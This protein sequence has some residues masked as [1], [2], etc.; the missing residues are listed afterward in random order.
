MF[1]KTQNLPSIGCQTL[2]CL[3]IALYILFEFRIPIFLIA[4]RQVRMK[5][6]AMP[7]ASVHKYRYLLA[8]KSDVYFLFTIMNSESCVFCEKMTKDLEHFKKG[9]DGR[10][11]WITENEF[12]FVILALHPKVTGHALIISKRH[13][14]DVTELN[15]Y[16]SQSLGSILVKTSKLLKQSLNAGKIYAMTM[17]EHWEPEE[18]NP[19]SKHGKKKPNTTE[20]FHLHL[21]PRYEEMR[22]KEIA[23]EHMF[24]RPEDYG[25]TLDMLNIVRER[26]L[27]NLS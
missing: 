4:F 14:K 8:W 23:Q 12:F 13:A 18:I 9:K 21:L 1:P 5:W 2:V 26:I 3:L 7:E 11:R 20:H 6:A 10:N 25:C 24:T 19:K 17:C 22:T 15:D 27:Q 16:E